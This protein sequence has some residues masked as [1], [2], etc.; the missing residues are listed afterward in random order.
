MSPTYLSQMSPRYFRANIGEYIRKVRV[1]KA[2]VLLSC[3]HLTLTQIAYDCGFSDQSHLIRCF[4]E[5][6]GMTPG[7]Y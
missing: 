2:T 6:N 4:K 5:F 3:K 1:D 7:Q